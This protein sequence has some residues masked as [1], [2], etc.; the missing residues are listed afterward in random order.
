M[1]L[2]GWKHVAG[3]VW[4]HASGLRIHLMG[5]C[6]LPCGGIV[7]GEN[8]PESKRLSRCIRIAGGNRKRGIMAWALERAKQIQ[9]GQA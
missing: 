5:V 4:D 1:K 8:W 9:G 7:Y 2:N 3:P 6:R